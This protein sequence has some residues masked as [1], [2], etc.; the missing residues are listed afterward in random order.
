MREEGGKSNTEETW[1]L[2][3]INNGDFCFMKHYL[4]YVGV[5]HRKLA[6]HKISINQSS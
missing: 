5:S 6:K 3:A 4:G 1:E 2:N